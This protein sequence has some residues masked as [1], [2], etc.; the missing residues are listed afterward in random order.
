MRCD[1]T[2]AIPDLTEQDTAEILTFSEIP[3]ASC[4]HLNAFV[5]KSDG[6]D[7]WPDALCLNCFRGI[8]P[9]QREAYNTKIKH[10]VISRTGETSYYCDAC[11]TPIAKVK[12]AEDCRN[13]RYVYARKLQEILATGQTLSN[14][15][16]DIIE[17]SEW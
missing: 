2:D 1:E 5:L 3:I 9:G 16:E 17:P 11:Y 13:C 4:V 10:F 12:P 7:H 14:Y 8:T 6:P 15:P